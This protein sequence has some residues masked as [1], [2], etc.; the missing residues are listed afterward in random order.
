M[1]KTSIQNFIPTLVK[2][3]I[4]Q[5]LI[6]TFVSTSL[7]LINKRIHVGK[8][9]GHL[10]VE[11]PNLQHRSLSDHG[12]IIVRPS[13]QHA[14]LSRRLSST[15]R[16]LESSNYE[17][18]LRVSFSHVDGIHWRGCEHLHRNR[19]LPLAFP[20]ILENVHHQTSPLQSHG[21]V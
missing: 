15:S 14:F 6:D 11:K 12:C 5:L 3:S 8:L 19:N 21:S 2:F 1:V 9:T 18:S 10:L 13:L 20:C 4:C 16:G 17:P 7:F